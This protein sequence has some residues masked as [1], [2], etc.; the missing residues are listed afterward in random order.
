[1]VQQIVMVVMVGHQSLEK[2]LATLGRC[3]LRF[4]LSF[5]K[6]VKFGA[7]LLT[8]RR[9]VVG[10]V[11]GSARVRLVLAV[12]N[13]TVVVSEAFCECG[14][15]AGFESLEGEASTTDLK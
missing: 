5:S 9:L 1:M 8:E 6:S 14:R 2:T 11:V 15:R 3:F 12:R 4:F 7:T 10:S 13:L